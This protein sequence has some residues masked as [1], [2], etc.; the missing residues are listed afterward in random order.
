MI[1]NKDLEEITCTVVLSRKSSTFEVHITHQL[2]DWQIGL[3][4]PSKNSMKAKKNIEDP[5]K[6]I[7]ILKCHRCTHIVWACVNVA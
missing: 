2:T 3:C 5:I 4:K 7:I 6:E 1:P